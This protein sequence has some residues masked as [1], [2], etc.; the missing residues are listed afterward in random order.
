[1]DKSILIISGEESGDLHGATLIRALKKLIPG[2]NVAGMG[3]WRM[4]EEGM[5][6]LDS[7]EVSVVGVVEGLSRLPRILKSMGA[8]KRQ[9]RGGRFDAGGVIDFPDFNLSIAKEA[10]RLRIPGIYYIS[11]QVWAW[12]K[13]RVGKIARLGN[14][15]LGVFPVEYFI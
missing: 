7:K 2:L 1:M 4:K 11:P 6:G 12:R 13:G 15:V 8:L 5:V 10:Q 3:G 9:M 14:R